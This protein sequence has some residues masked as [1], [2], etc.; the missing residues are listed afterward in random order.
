MSQICFYPLNFHIFAFIYKMNSEII[1]IFAKQPNNF[2][3]K[4][5]KEFFLTLIMAFMVFT[6]GNVNAQTYQNLWK[7][8]DEAAQ[9]DLPQTQR[10]VL[11]QIVAKAEREA[12]YGHLLKALLTDARVA[13]QVSPDSLQPVVDEL[14]A[15]EQRALSI[16]LQA[17]Y[18]T[19]LAYIYEHNSSLDENWQ[20]VAQEYKEH[21]MIHPAELAAVKA[22]DYEPFLERG[23]D[24][25]LYENDLLSVI[26]YETQQFE[27]L[28]QYYLTTPNRKAQ[29]F[30]AL[31]VLETQS[32]AASVSCVDSLIA[33]YNDLEEC[34]EAAILRLQLMLR[35]EHSTAKEQVE[36][37]DQSLSR[38]GKWK[39]MNELRNAR[40]ALTARNFRAQLEDYVWMP[41]RQQNVTL[42][43]LRGISS[44]TMTLYKVNADGDI[45]LSPNRESDYRKLKPLLT[46]L[47]NAETRHY[48]GHA[49]YE[50][51]KD[52]FQ[53]PALPVGVYMIEFKT[54][55]E[56]QVD[57]KLYFVSD[58]RVLAQ[59]LPANQMRYV[60]VNATTGQPIPGASL[61]LKNASGRQNGSVVTLTTNSE[62][63]CLYTTED[64]R[65]REIY[66]AMKDDRACPPINAYGRYA[67]SEQNGELERGEVMT[68]RAIYRPG[69]TVSVAALF[70]TVKN[71]FEHQ[72]MKGHRVKAVLRDANY[73][74]VTEKELVTDDFGTATTSF[75]LPTTVLT[76][77][78]SVSVG[79]KSAFFQVEEYKRPT[80]QV[81]IPKPEQDYRAGDTLTLSGVAR[82]YAGVP[83]Q[84]A[85]VKYK[86]ERRRAWWWV[87]NY[88]YY[89]MF[90]IGQTDL[91]AEVWSAETYTDADGRFE[92]KMPMVLP[93]VESQLFCNFVLVADV[94]DQAGETH[95][96][97]LSLPLGNRKTALS[98]DLEQQVLRESNSQLA[99]HLR[100]A[101]GTELNESVSYRIDSGKWQSIATRQQVALPSLKS[102]RHT[103]E[104]VCAGDS[105]RQEFVVFSLSDKQPAT[106]TDD[107][108]YVSDHVFPNDGKP[109]TVQVGSSDK[110]V[111]IVYSIVSGNQVVEK[112]AVDKSGALLNRQFIYKE[113]YGNGLALS[114]IWMKNGKTYQH[115][116]TLRRP[117]PDKQLRMKWETF[118][119]RLIPGQ[120]EEWTLS[121][122]SPQGQQ[123][124][125][126]AQLMAVLYDK[127]L[128]QLKEH[129]WSF[130]PFINL[131]LPYLRWY[132]G[133]WGALAFVGSYQRP[134]LGV[135]EL[136]FSHFDA[137]CYPEEWMR[138]RG[139]RFRQS[140][141]R[142]MMM[143]KASADVF[144]SVSNEALQGSTA[145]LSM[146]E[147]AVQDTAEYEE[148]AQDDTT[149]ETLQ[150][151]STRQNLQET[152]FFYP[153]LTTDESG[154]VAI[155]FTLP[156]SLTTWRF[157]GLAHTAD[158]MYGLLE[159]EAVAQKDVM[160]QPNVPRF[161]RLGDEASVSA[162]VI[163]TGSKDVSAE[164]W[165]TLS[166][167]ET[168]RV[169]LSKQNTLLI[170]ADSTLAVSFPVNVSQLEGQ[171]L[172][173]CKM[174]VSGEGF[175]DGEQYYLPVLP[176]E[177][178]VTVTVPFVQTEP[179]TK[180]L[181]LAELFP[182]A[183][184]SPK[185]TI[186]YTNNP[187]WFMIQ[188][189]PFVSEPRD[190]CAISQAASFYANSLGLHILRQNPSARNVFESWHR[191]K[192]AETS[193]MSALQ[194]NEELKDIV[195][196]ETPWVMDAN[197]EAEQKQ[198]LADFFDEN[199]MN[200]RLASAVTQLAKLQQTDGSWSW[201]E[202][203][204]GSFFITVE[205]SEMLVRL[206]QMTGADSFQASNL[207]SQLDKAYGFM[208]SE[209]LK[210]VEEMKKEE[211]KGHPQTFPSQKA[212][213][214]L[215][216]SALDGRK[217]A[218]VVASA[219]TYL[220]NLLKKEA[221][222][223]TIYDKAMA[224]IVLNSQLYVKSLKEWTTYKADM[225]RY[226]DTP[227][228]GY[229]WCD[230]RIPTQ[231]AVIEALKR[232]TPDDK[233]TINEMQQWLLQQKR[234]QAWDTPINSVNA[235]YAFLDTADGS[236]VGKSVLTAQPHTR[237]TLNEK[238]LATSEATAGIGY[239]K[240]SVPL[241]SSQERVGTLKAEKISTGTSWGAVYAQ[242]MQPTRDIADQGS[243]VSIKREIFAAN[244]ST[245]SAPL[246]VGQ[247][248]RVRL[249]ITA[250]RNLDFVEIIDR[251]A[252]C[253]EPVVQLSGYRNGAYC[254]HKDN[255]THYYYDML[256][257]G[258]HVI[259]TEYYIDRT[260]RYET[261]T[262]IVQCA[263]APEFRGTTHSLTLTVTE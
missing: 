82:S 65:S 197:R 156:E 144:D 117:L 25:K 192:G 111:H 133:A 98:V 181:S 216:L 228:A 80:F 56:T 252:A 102:G 165:L 208:D 63:E 27:K 76:G 233:Q 149:T 89:D 173:V 150:Q 91:N 153:Q 34:G 62:G 151:P 50:L 263:Y 57:C 120:Q 131:P 73:Q 205:V 85:H 206:Q 222:R 104:A 35:D 15:R 122:A 55:P 198:R 78:F 51:F 239:V 84:G 247:R 42:T 47:P 95:H 262:C 33:L 170:P 143:T 134:Y 227:R 217:P 59:P 92:A 253:M 90:S 184:S 64:S 211:R 250:Q 94:T 157:M 21:A 162:R 100:N 53:L 195:L 200:S 86:V 113:V 125:S 219:Q 220:K 70:Y 235:I 123:L 204:R 199:L 107:W 221:R 19:A 126:Q 1:P 32:P 186:E 44:L 256:S 218:S 185:L 4:T 26:G 168:D 203:M 174:T 188:A 207:R 87:T 28:H 115:T 191:E 160:I 164:V 249:T 52:S 141:G 244:G 223:L 180:A 136:S 97:E 88:R 105:L 38:W 135:D 215:Y 234:T 240:T 155:K 169:L 172:L 142:P 12:Q 238:P 67:F 213:Q 16:P 224:A 175:S 201:W 18:Q 226:Y 41:H 71:G 128:D 121:I 11:K 60:V 152:A 68:D 3:E 110:D 45:Q 99:F 158:L 161:V 214:Y 129:Q 17:V 46:A 114:F 139:V 20:K 242:F 251:R 196:N 81:E 66:A 132:S 119:D 229:S 61:H 258:K 202:G 77:R 182:K 49:E 30:S 31:K 43:Q 257:K 190:Y 194:K 187:A 69:Q 116:A 54:E 241:S 193:L 14:K 209:I 243:E 36:Y 8:V 7:Q 189:L 236:P 101:A 166:D 148:A 167:P 40:N 109:V 232:L 140:M 22:T 163:N 37:I 179:G 245:L 231:V 112:G 130:S 2:C 9:Q 103:L 106:E 10:G 93:Q 210:L 183:V 259:E 124:S 79:G 138:L 260:G 237:L 108:F 225:G 83:V 154:R 248:I 176:N 246:K 74:A 23:S 127:S 261:G 255:A 13:A 96:G 75:T 212:L 118:R 48:V 230:Y 6:Q 146:E 171:S 58:V 177:E 178:R 29:L 5:M 147:K 254:T 72:V 39:R 159:G 145:E 24:S 137:S